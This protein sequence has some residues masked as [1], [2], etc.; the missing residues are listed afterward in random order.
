MDSSFDDDSYKLP[1]DSFN[2]NILYTYTT[3]LLW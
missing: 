1:Q 2:V 3:S